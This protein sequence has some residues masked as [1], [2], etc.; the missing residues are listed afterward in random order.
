MKSSCILVSSHLNSLAKEEVAL[1]TL[2]SLKESG[3]PIIL[4]GNFPINTSLQEIADYTLN[5]K[6]NPK[7][8]RF[9]EVFKNN[10]RELLPDYGFAHLHQISKGF[11][12]CEAL[13]YTYV[14]HFNYDVN[15]DKENLTKFLYKG[16][17]KDFTWFSWG[18][19]GINLNL[20]SIS[21][22]EF[23]NIIPPLFPFY[24]KNLPLPRISPNWY[25][26]KFAKRAFEINDIKF[27]SPSDENIVYSLGW[28]ENSF[29]I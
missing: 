9:L 20:F 27:P 5:I 29:G 6:E 24:K 26:E 15:I 11:Y 4:V 2:T 21:T 23:L 8:N 1:K 28:S 16:L 3:L 13:N 19:D 25:A 12:L 17:S 7:V 14:Y 18:A 10:Q 22:K